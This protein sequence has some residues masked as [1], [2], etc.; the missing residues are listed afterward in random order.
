MQSTSGPFSSRLPT[1]LMALAVVLALIGVGAIAS[2]AADKPEDELAQTVGST[3]TTEV[4]TATT[5]PGVGGVATTVAGGT[6]ATTAKTTGTTGG[7]TPTTTSAACPTPPAA[8]ADPGPHTP[9]AVGTYT[10]AD[11]AD[12]S[13]TLDTKVTDGGSG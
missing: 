1:V 4:G 13:D 5:L 9:P 3:T 6:T 12:S 8:S 10:Y 7:T 2:G 11:C